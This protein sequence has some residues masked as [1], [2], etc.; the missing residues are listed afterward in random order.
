[1]ALYIDASPNQHAVWHVG[2]PTSNSR[3]WNA[4]E[5]TLQ[6]DGDELEYIRH[7][8]SNVPIANKRVV[9]WHGEFA[10]FIA[11]NMWSAKS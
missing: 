5:I 11:T 8:F 3:L 10:R 1:M 7:N 9:R 2:E 6:A 4:S